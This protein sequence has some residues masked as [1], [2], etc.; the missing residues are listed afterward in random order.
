MFAYPHLEKLFAAADKFDVSDGMK[1]YLR[2]HDL[3]AQI[4]AYYDQQHNLD[5]VVAAF[6]AL[7]PNNDYKGNLR[8]LVTMLYAMK[9][10][11]DPEMATVSTYKAC[12]TRAAMYLRG[13]KFMSHAKGLKTRAFYQNISDPTMME[14]VT[15]DG[16]M[17]LAYFGKTGTMKDAQKL[18]SVSVY[19]EIAEAVRN[20]ARD[21]G[22][23]P[24][25]MQAILWMARKRIQQVVYD[26]Q[27]DLLAGADDGAQKTMFKPSEIKPYDTIYCSSGATAE[28]LELEPEYKQMVM[29]E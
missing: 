24:H 12:R 23:I 29:F 10:W 25:Q 21:R 20:M 3:M 14:P 1:A 22:I 9:A 16:H 15:V 7:S 27:F 13:V 8:S 28:D 19:R 5:G 6:C 11:G 2:Y 26:P 17:V 18:L 4:A